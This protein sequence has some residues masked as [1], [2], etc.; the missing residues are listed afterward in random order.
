MNANYVCELGTLAYINMRMFPAT[1]PCGWG[2]GTRW[3]VESADVSKVRYN[4]I[5][6]KIMD[7]GS[8]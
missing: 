4:T 7:N 2:S 6:S 5:I 3:D 8:G 1:C